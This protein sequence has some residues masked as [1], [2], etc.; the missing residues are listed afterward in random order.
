M[1]AL[2]SEIGQCGAA[3]FGIFYRTK[4]P[5]LTLRELIVVT[6]ATNVASPY[7]AARMTSESGSVHGPWECNAS[8][9]MSPEGAGSF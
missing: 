2:F 7:T 4:S 5:S 6:L 9:V 8:H 3:L 1:A